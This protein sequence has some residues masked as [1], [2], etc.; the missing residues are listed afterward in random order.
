V[1]EVNGVKITTAD[2]QERVRFAR[3]NL[4]NQLSTLA[5]YQQFGMDVTQQQQQIMTTLQL[6][7][8]MGQQVLD[9]MV[10]EV[11][12]R[13]EAEKRGITVTTEEVDEL[14]QEAF[15]FFPNGT[16]TPT[17]TPTEL[18]VEHPTLNSEQLTLYPSTSTPTPFLTATA[19]LTSTPDQSVTATATFTP[20]PPTPTFVPQ[21]P[22]ATSTPYTLEG[23]E[24]QY[25]DSLDD[26]KNYN[27]G[28]KT[29]RTVYEIDI[30]RNKLRE[31]L[32]KDLPHTETQVLVR[33]IL[34]A[35]EATAQLVYDQLQAGQDF[36]KLAADFSQ[37]PGSSSNGGYYD[38]APA[39]NYV[40]EF[41]DATLTQEIG[42]IGQP[43]KTEFGYHVIQ[44]IGRAELPV[45]DSQFEQK[46]QTN[47]E[48]W[49]TTARE[50]ADI[51]TFDIWK[52]RVPTEP[53]LQ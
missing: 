1:A 20:A 11:L 15:N 49:L 53:V 48:D 29:L 9:E 34:V 7:E 3:V 22:T 18:V 13:Q 2:W 44:V 50:S 52:T 12:I 47:L 10:D 27:I 25:D 43:V 17:I 41:R 45:T 4:Y 19:E 30:L 16:A 38:W 51:Q 5:F 23:F 42:V 32:A 14:I 24:Q 35:D 21:S 39:S 40:P 31:E 37:D 46:K 28:E 26:F 6:P 36:A 8:L 33:H